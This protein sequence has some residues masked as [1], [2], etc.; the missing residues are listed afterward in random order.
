VVAARKLGSNRGAHRSSGLGRGHQDAN[1]RGG[2]RGIARR[3]TTHLAHRTLVNQISVR[4][5]E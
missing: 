4:E 5:S 3:A 1:G 2:E